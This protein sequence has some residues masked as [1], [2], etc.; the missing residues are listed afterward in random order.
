MNI[1][2]SFFWKKESIFTFFILVTAL[3]NYA[4]DFK[5]YNAIGS[6]YVHP[7]FSSL[8]KA[9]VH[10]ES[11]FTSLQLKV[12]E[13]LNAT[14]PLPL[15]PLTLGA[16]IH[17]GKT[18]GS[19]LSSQLLNG[20]H[21]FV[22]K[23]C[24]RKN[25]ELYQ[26]NVVS[27]LTTYFH[28]PDFITFPEKNTSELH[29]N[30]LNYE[31][32][33]FTSRD[34]LER[35][36]SSYL[37][38]HPE[39]RVIEAFTKSKARIMAS[40]DAKDLENKDFVERLLKLMER[41]VHFKDIKG[42]DPKTCTILY[43]C[44]PTLESYAK[45]LSNVHAYEPG[46]WTEFALKGNCSNVA[47]MTVHHGV[48]Q[49]IPHHYWDLRRIL[50]ELREVDF[51]TKTV[52]VSRT[53]KLAQD[54]SGIN[55]YLGQEGN[56]TLSTKLRDSTKHEYPIKNVLSEEG[57]K[58]LCFAME[59]EYR[60]YLKLLRYAENLSESDLSESFARANKNCP[61]LKLTMPTGKEDRM[62]IQYIDSE[63]GGNRSDFY[64]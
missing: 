26:E 5:I 45:A 33:V 44:F 54:W 36:I 34:P 46:N 4:Y 63:L 11:K 1:M 37:A 6:E 9:P 58:K 47:K 2:I 60:V 19:T 56:I 52:L 14:Y 40:P 49:D 31:F 7:R 35:A 59:E 55:R 17:V 64:F 32:F 41:R 61:W 51:S 42:K 48:K 21:S 3:H 28:T 13:K 38:S 39:N 15:P 30:A 53:D 24:D 20:C 50:Y 43:R 57:K 22:A 62:L 23:P 25:P 29:K 18:G 16:F 27:K 12:M 8:Q 10:N